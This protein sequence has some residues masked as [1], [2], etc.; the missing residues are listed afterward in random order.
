MAP[1]ATPTGTEYAA[2]VARGAVTLS[3]KGEEEELLV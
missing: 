3:G 1:T 2:G